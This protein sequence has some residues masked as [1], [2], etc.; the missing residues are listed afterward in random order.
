M[1]ETIRTEDRNKAIGC[2]F[3]I[4]ELNLDSNKNVVI[5]KYNE[6]QRIKSRLTEARNSVRLL[7]S[8]LQELESEFRL[9][10]PLVELEFSVN[11]KEWESKEVHTLIINKTDY[12]NTNIGS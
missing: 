6:I 2:T 12:R 11:E 10:E 9:I 4:N 1:K 8:T 5:T 3:K 7:E